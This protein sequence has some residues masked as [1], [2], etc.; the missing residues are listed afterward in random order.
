MRKWTFKFVKI[1]IIFFF[2]N[3]KL[4]ILQKL[5]KRLVIFTQGIFPPILKKIWTLVAE[6]QMLTDGQTD[7]PTDRPTTRHGN[8]SS[9]PKK[10]KRRARK[11]GTGWKQVILRGF[12][13]SPKRAIKLSVFSQGLKLTEYIYKLLNVMRYAKLLITFKNGYSTFDWSNKCNFLIIVAPAR[14]LR[15]GWG[16]YS[17][18]CQKPQC[19]P[20]KSILGLGLTCLSIPCWSAKCPHGSLTHYPRA[21]DQSDDPDLWDFLPLFKEDSS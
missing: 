11:C 5:K 8:R 12:L 20:G 16:V 13:R 21:A 17:E 1:E 9:G 19:S 15:T 2:L 4:K 6:L 14:S 18:K 10:I 7:R 3:S